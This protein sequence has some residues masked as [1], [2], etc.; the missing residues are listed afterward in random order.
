LQSASSVSQVGPLPAEP[1]LITG[2]S[3]RE[4]VRARS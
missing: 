2:C 1:A 3:A 4:N